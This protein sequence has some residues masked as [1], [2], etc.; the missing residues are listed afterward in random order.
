[1]LAFV[2]VGKKLPVNGKL[3]SAIS[4]WWKEDILCAASLFE[5]KTHTFLQDVR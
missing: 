2:G 1:M 3:N 4:S 5:I